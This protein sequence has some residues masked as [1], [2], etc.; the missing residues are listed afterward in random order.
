MGGPPG[1]KVLALVLPLGLDTFALAAALGLVG[2]EPRDRVRVTL[3][4]AG[5]ELAMPLAGYAAGDLAGGVAGTAAD[6]LA[7]ALLAGIGLYLLW[8]RSEEAEAARLGLF[9]R[10]RG[11]AALGLGLSIS[12]D[13]LAMGVAIGLLRQPILLVA[14][15]VA[16]Q[17]AL[18]TQLG[19]RLGGRVGE[20]GREWSE[21]GAGLILLALAAI[22]LVE[23]LSGRGLL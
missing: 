12:L 9:G 22:L 10:A 8:P 20:R 15:L 16:A 11:W 5:F 14:V 17:A 23:R 1:M 2:L 3:L 4:F 18:A 21:R 13:E 19:L 7:I 6:F